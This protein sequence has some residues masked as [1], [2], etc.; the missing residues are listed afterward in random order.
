M[1][2]LIKQLIAKL[3]NKIKFIFDNCDKSQKK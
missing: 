2:L 3:N 1:L